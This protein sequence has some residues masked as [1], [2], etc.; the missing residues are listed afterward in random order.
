M[1]RL[2]RGTKKNLYARPKKKKNAPTE[3]GTNKMTQ[4]ETDRQNQNLALSV[5]PNGLVSGEVSVNKSSGSRGFT[6]T[7]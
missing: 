6:E 5:K 1:K 3:M 7:S 4:E 2:D